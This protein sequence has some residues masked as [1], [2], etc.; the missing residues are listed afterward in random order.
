MSKILFFF[1]TGCV[2]C[3]LQ[4]NYFKNIPFLSKKQTIWNDSDLSSTH[5][6]LSMKLQKHGLAIPILFTLD[7]FH[8]SK[9]DQICIQGT[10]IF[11]I[12]LKL[13]INMEFRWCGSRNKSCNFKQKKLQCALTIFALPGG[14]QVLGKKSTFRRKIG[15]I[16][17]N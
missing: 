2:V 6:T 15:L 8:S 5:V 14:H 12:K 4:K 3:F 9:T 10:S 11:P 17:N 13:S 16:Y 7:V 1:C